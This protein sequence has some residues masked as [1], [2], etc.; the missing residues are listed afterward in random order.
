MS[1]TALGARLAFRHEGEFVHAY[2]A[3]VGTMEDA[4]LIS[5]FRHSVLVNQPGLFDKWKA[6]VSESY[7][8]AIENV[9]GIR[10]DL[11]EEEGPEH[12]RGG[13]A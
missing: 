9:T 13:H 2:H 8:Q 4:V 11:I 12:E 5:S 6:I 1:K 3:Q 7:A 10:P